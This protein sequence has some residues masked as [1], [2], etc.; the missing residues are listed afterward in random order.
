MCALRAPG[1]F[2]SSGV[3][4]LG[5]SEHGVALLRSL[6][7]CSGCMS[8]HAHFGDTLRRASAAP[9]RGNL[10]HRRVGVRPICGASFASSH[11]AHFL[12]CGGARCVAEDAVLAAVGLFGWRDVAHLFAGGAARRVALPLCPACGAPRLLAVPRRAAPRSTA[13]VLPRRARRSSRCRRQRAH[14][15]VS[16][17]PGRADDGVGGHVYAQRGAGRARAHRP[18]AAGGWRAAA[19]A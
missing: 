12:Q 2:G 14:G 17:I 19:G 5:P 18:R 9:R 3:S 10:P 15:P 11:A 7:P 13:C 6:P 1:K 8:L 16:D 4:A